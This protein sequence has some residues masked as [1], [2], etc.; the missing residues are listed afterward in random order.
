ML[1][2]ITFIAANPGLAAWLIGGLFSVIGL[3][4]GV[5]Y[6]LLYV[7][8]GQL[9]ETDKKLTDRVGEVEEKVARYEEHV[10]AGE[11]ALTALSARIERHMVEEENMV[12]TGVKSLGDKL[13][14]IQVENVEAHATIQKEYGDRLAQNGE[15]L[16]KIEGQVQGI[17]RALPNGELQ[18]M[19][20]LLR[21]LVVV[22]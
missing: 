20:D 11:R 17:K 7:R 1:S 2:I 6:K 15:R 19:L 4:V 14:E 16:A 10:G 8:L 12:W 5:Y 3:L 22:K 9:E 13:N 21:K 18:E